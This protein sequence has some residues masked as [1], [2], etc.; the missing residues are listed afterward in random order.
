MGFFELFMLAV[1]LSMDAFSVSICKGLGMKKVNW[2]I[3]LALAVAFGGFQAGM[4]VI[5]WALGSQFLWLI[6]PVDHWIAFI[7]LVFIGGNMIREA[8][9][10]EEE[11][12]GT[13]DHIDLGELLMLAVATSIDALTVGIAFA[14]LSVNIWLSVALI[15][16]TTFAFSIAGVLIGNQFGMRYQKPSQIAGGIILILIG[17]KVLLEHLGILVL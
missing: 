2:G 5:G 16:V 11:D 3:A 1:G 14:S 12:T 6:E 7:L 9:S 10:D 4:P 8:L 13:V 17:T 15:G